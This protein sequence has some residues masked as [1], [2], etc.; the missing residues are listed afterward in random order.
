MPSDNKNCAVI[1]S[2]IAGIATAIR[3]VQKGYKVTVYEKNASPGGKLTQIKIKEYRFDF[4]PSLLTLPENI[5]E[6]FTLCGKKTTDY[7]RYNL[8]N[9]GHRYFYEDGKIFSAYHPTDKFI[10]EAQ[11]FFN[12]PTLSIRKYLNDSEKKYL[13]TKDMFLS[14]SLHKFKSYLSKASIL[15]FLNFRKLESFKTLDKSHRRRFKN[16]K[17]IQY[18]N[19]FSTYNGSS[20][21]RAPATLGLIPH[22][23]I[24][25]GVYYPEGGMYSI[26]TALVKLA[27]DM[28]VQFVFNQLVEEI[29]ITDKKVTGI[30]TSQ[31]I[32]DYNLVIS[33]M[34]VYYTYHKLLPFIKKPER[35]LNQEKSY[36]GIVFYWCINKSFPELALHNILWSEEYEKE[37]DVLVNKK[38]IYN[39]PTIYLNITSKQTPT[40]AP[41]G[42]EN[43]FVM[44][45]A[46]HNTGQD[47]NKLVQDVRANVITKINR[48]LKTNIENF[49]EGEEIT[50]PIHPAISYSNT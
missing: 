45:N 8:V 50:T 20:P 29:C 13:L 37:F 27:N 7:F 43:W 41:E 21:Y 15:S 47:W 26:T 39:D 2:G 23:E 42:C 4:G 44:I 25:L 28:G 14:K 32:Y 31:G 12:E 17:L 38:L 34:D 49:I 22:L 33:N 16:K 9:P 40:D 3:L 30:K 24:G 1:G 6:L 5:E 35:I 19:R 18:F 11:L 10:E 46:P 36:S 48:I